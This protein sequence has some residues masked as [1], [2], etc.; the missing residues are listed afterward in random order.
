M[1][2]PI[3]KSGRTRK[4]NDGRQLQ[5]LVELIESKLI[6]AGFRVETNWSEFD[7]EGNYLAEF[8][9]QFIGTNENA[10]IKW[11]IECRDRPS[12]GPAPGAWIEQLVGRRSRFKFDKVTAVSSSGF[13]KGAQDYAVAEGIELKQTEAK[14]LADFSKWLH[15]N[16][17]DWNEYAHELKY[18]HFDFILPL[19]AEMEAAIAERFEE[20]RTTGN[21]ETPFVRKN[22]DTLASLM[23][24]FQW[25]TNEGKEREDLIPN[26]PPK[27]VKITA[28]IDSA[29]VYELEARGVWFRIKTLTFIGEVR[30]IRKK[31][32]PNQITEYRNA[33]T[34][35]MISQSV[36]FEPME[37]NGYRYTTEM[38]QIP[39]SGFIHVIPKIEP[40]TSVTAPEM[41]SNPKARDVSAKITGDPAFEPYFGDPK[42]DGLTFA[43]VYVNL[44]TAPRSID[45][46]N[47]ELFDGILLT[48][49][50]SSK[51]EHLLLGSAI[52]VAPGVALTASHTFAGYEDKLKAGEMEAS[53]FGITRHGGV[54]W[55]VEYITAVRDSDMSI[56]GL[57][58]MV[59]LPPD[60]KFNLAYVTTRTPAMG[61]RLVV[62]GFRASEKSFP[63]DAARKNVNVA[64]S[65]LICSGTVIG[66]HPKGRD[67][68]LAPYPCV[69][70][71][72]P[73]WGGMSGG[74]VFDMQGRLVGLNSRSWET[75]DE[76]SPMV[77]SLMWPAMIQRFDGGWP[78]SHSQKRLIETQ[79]R[80]ERPDALAFSQTKENSVIEWV[81]TV[82]T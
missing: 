12:S 73:M 31:I 46:T 40:L 68:V 59:A 44:Q 15:L 54:N 82:W 57:R 19:D 32:A 16:A 67:R 58:Y 69:E 36:T 66:L 37:H 30:L 2:N 20:L 13:A 35:E 25:A 9:I 1:S 3:K 33:T 56:L 48:V 49:M 8:D 50:I 47:W 61:E 60:R 63:A 77:A 78:F 43:R 21:Y 17:S 79:P 24:L 64:G 76:P 14:E 45:V 42:D 7:A 39:G 71:D 55:K 51:E 11:L 72:C 52:I 22:G 28:A 6:P 62:A 65:L 74:P 10:G 53:C 38:H 41:P 23:S 75:P 80:I 81:Y 5:D 34:G 4:G 70:I 29:A 26:G 27:A 18:V